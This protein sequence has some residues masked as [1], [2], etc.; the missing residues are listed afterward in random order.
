MFKSSNHFQFFLQIQ[1]HVEIFFRNILRFIFFLTFV[2]L[3]CL[4]SIVFAF[5]SLYISI[6]FI[7]TLVL[8]YFQLKFT[9]FLLTLDFTLLLH[10]KSL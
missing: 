5:V 6:L 7:F 9:Y 2:T 8:V 4:F 3:Y 10:K 1:F